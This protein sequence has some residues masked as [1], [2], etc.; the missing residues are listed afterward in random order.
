LSGHER[1]EICMKASNKVT[2]GGGSINP[3]SGDFATDNVFYRVKLV[4]GA[5]TLDW[6]GT[7]AGGLTAG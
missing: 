7:Y 2:V 1:P 3:M 6:R 4:F 5:T